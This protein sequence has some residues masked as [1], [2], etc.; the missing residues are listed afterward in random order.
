MKRSSLGNHHFR[1]A[2]RSREI[3]KKKTCPIV[4]LSKSP[5]KPRKLSTRISI[6]TDVSIFFPLPGYEKTVSLSSTFAKEK[7]SIFFLYSQKQKES[8]EEEE[9][10]TRLKTLLVEKST[11]PRGVAFEWSALEFSRKYHRRRRTFLTFRLVAIRGWRGKTNFKS[12][13]K[14]KAGGRAGG[15]MGVEGVE[16]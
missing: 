13:L 15:W 1:S 10:L 8:E 7:Y 9:E 3:K 14:T 12:R 11:W 4:P 5:S 6:H 16:G 2:R